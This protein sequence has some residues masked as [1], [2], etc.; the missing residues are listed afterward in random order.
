MS[1][2][3]TNP[4]DPD[5]MANNSSPFK[6]QFLNDVVRTRSGENWQNVFLP[7][8]VPH[9]S[10][11]DTKA[12]AS[13]GWLKIEP[14]EGIEL[15]TDQ[16]TGHHSRLLKSDDLDLSNVTKGA[17]MGRLT[18]A[19][20]KRIALLKS[21]GAEEGIKVSASSEADCKSFILA[22]DLEKP[23]IFLLRNGNLRA[24]WK[25]ASRQIGLQFFG[26]RRGAIV[27]LDGDGLEPDKILGSHKLDVLLGVVEG[28][29]F[30]KVWEKKSRSRRYSE[31]FRQK[32][33][34]FTGQG[35]W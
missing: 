28:A 18:S 15:T 9:S 5:P 35:I 1:Q 8:I 10:N 13:K 25:R 2:R 31:V 29:G 20:A 32:E 12:R 4:I 16:W 14:W 34:A 6:V 27:M 24:V 3:T 11:A 26:D 21:E 7:P 33:S 30:Q 22:M 17:S 23:A 19:I